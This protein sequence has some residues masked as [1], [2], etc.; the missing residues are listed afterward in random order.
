VEETIV[1]DIWGDTVEVAPYW[2][3]AKKRAVAQLTAAEGDQVVTLNLDR[4]GARKVAKALRRVARHLP[5]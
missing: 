5:S 1:K 3:G 2:D 4:K